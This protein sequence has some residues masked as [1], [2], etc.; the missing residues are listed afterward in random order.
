MERTLSTDFPG[1]ELPIGILIAGVDPDGYIG[2]LIINTVSVP[3]PTTLGLFGI[4]LAGL[5]FTRRR[6]RA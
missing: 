3:E 2:S 5:A 1:P 6:N 4:G